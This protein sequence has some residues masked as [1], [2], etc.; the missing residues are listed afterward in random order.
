MC[1]ALPGNLAKMQA[2][3]ASLKWSLRFCISNKLPGATDAAGSWTTTMDQ[4]ILLLIQLLLLLGLYLHSWSQ[5]SANKKDQNSQKTKKPPNHP[6][7]SATFLPSPLLLAPQFPH[8]PPSWSRLHKATEEANMELKRNDWYLTSLSLGE[9]N[10]NL[11]L[12]WSGGSNSKAT[13]PLWLSM[14][15]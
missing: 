2:N 6:S 13:S 1:T 14:A 11:M 8:H 5:Q 12:G 10:L 9:K 3:S 15:S 4:T 7:F